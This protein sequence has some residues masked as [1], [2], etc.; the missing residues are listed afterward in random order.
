MQIRW[1][2]S[3]IS[4]ADDRFLG[5]RDSSLE[6]EIGA[7]KRAR[8]RWMSI[9]MRP[10]DD[11]HHAARV[12]HARRDSAGASTVAAPAG[13]STE[14]AVQGHA[15]DSDAYPAIAPSFPLAAA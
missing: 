4:V 2:A 9:A 12:V 10:R 7:R 1:N 15:R 14:T 13:E 8:G 11:V 5:A 3:G 6:A